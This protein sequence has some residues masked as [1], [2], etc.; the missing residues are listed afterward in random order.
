MNRKGVII[1]V[2]DEPGILETLS[3]QLEENFGQTHR[4]ETAQSGEEALEIVEVLKEE[5]EIIEMVITDQVMPGMK[6]AELLETI[7]ES[8]PDVIKILLTGQAGLSSAIQAINYG[9]L[10]RYIEK[11][12]DMDKL[13]A[14]I[15]TLIERFRQNLENQYLINRLERRIQELETGS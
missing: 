1:C 10:D 14:D 15:Q 11:P 12:W 8:M 13:K 2:D 5:D 3:Q 6:G 4:V 7:N 9:G